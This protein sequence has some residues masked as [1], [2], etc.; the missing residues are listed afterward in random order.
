MI[1]TVRNLIAAVVVY[2]AGPALKVD[3]KGRLAELIDA[4][5]FPACLPVPGSMVAGEGLEP[6]TSG[7]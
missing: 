5:A 1:A 2:I 7:L 6:P 4:D 3:L